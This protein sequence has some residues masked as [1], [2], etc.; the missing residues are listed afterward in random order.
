[1]RQIMHKNSYSI[2]KWFK[3]NYLDSEMN[4][5][6]LDVGS[7]DSSKEFL[8]KDIFNEDN[9][10]YALLS[11]RNHSKADIVV[12]DI[13]N[14]YEI[15]DDS[16]DVIVSSHFFEHLEFFWLTLSQIERV[17]KPGGLICIIVPSAGG[18]HDYDL[19]NC[20]RF[21]TGGLQAMAK[22]IGFEIL[23]A[24]VDEKAEAKPYYDGC[25]I[26]SKPK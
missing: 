4:L 15:E 6:I 8:Y 9:W 17:L 23:Y 22:Y 10:N 14:W 11:N 13:Y 18:K 3:E 7:I 24:A 1:M 20:Y 19:A 12:S 2:M 5:D 21:H 16:Y 26:A 25:L